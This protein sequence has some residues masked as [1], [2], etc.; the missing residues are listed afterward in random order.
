[1]LRRTFLHLHGVGEATERRW[2]GEGWTDWS[3]Y[4]SARDP[5]GPPAARVENRRRVEECDACWSRGAW[6]RLDR[7]LPASVHWRAYGDFAETA[8]YL[9]LETAG[10]A[11]NTI[12]L[13]GLFDGRTYRPYIAGRDLDE[14]LRQIDRY[15]LLVTFN[16]ALFDLPVLRAHFRN[17][18]LN[19]LHI[20]LRYPSRRL[21]LRGGL[22]R[23]EEALGLRRPAEVRGLDG[24]DAVRLWAEYRGGSRAALDRLVAYNREDTQNLKTLMEEVWARLSP[25]FA[26]E[27]PGGRAPEP[28]PQPSR[29]QQ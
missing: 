18:P 12:T 5:P 24:W 29:F 8:L 28:R 25:T 1:M 27:P 13:I 11:A 16:G 17:E 22:K 3:D 2:W 14:A 6:G 21:G 7:L 9:D 4:L 15:P 19:A 20:D 23:I 10:D 26:E